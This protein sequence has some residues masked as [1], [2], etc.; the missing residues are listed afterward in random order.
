MIASTQNNQKIKLYL[1]IPEHFSILVYFFLI[2]LMI[3]S[4][5]EFSNMP[6]RTR[7]S[8]RRGG[9]GGVKLLLEYIQFQQTV[10]CLKCYSM[11][12]RLLTVSLNKTL[13]CHEFAA[14]YLHMRYSIKADH[15]F[16]SSVG[17]TQ[18]C[19]AIQKRWL[20]Q[21]RPALQKSTATSVIQCCSSYNHQACF[22][23]WCFMY[24]CIIYIYNLV[25][26][27]GGMGQ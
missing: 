1:P 19:D 20:I 23:S 4:H 13:N 9:R 12:M 6:N 10:L 2:K 25:V 8:E 14:L 18:R 27:W 17:C 26:F 15:F 7:G 11:M 3:L 24:I 22:P 21:L 16:L 5:R